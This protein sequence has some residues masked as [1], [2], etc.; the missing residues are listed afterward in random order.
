MREIGLTRDTALQMLREFGLERNQV[1]EFKTV[2]IVLN[3]MPYLR[4]F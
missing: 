1:I 2:S 4:N 3:Y